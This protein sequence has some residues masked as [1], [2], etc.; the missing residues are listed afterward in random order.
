MSE[1]KPDELRGH[2]Y[3]GIEEYDNKLPNWWLFILYGSIVF[4]VGYWLVFHTF[5]IVDLPRARY[6]KEMVQAS[7]VQLAR[8]AKTGLTDESLA[9]MATI[10]AQVEEG[11]QLYATYCVVCHAD[12]GQGLVGPNLTDGFWIHGGRPLD[13]HKTVTDGVLS[14]GMAAWGRQLGPTRVQKVVAYV[15]TLKGTEVPGKAPEGVPEAAA[16]PA[17]PA[18]GTTEPV[19]GAAPTPEGAAGNG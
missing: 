19:S 2:V 15:L 14:K 6:D 5:S 16:A 11:R 4:A 7:E 13:I 12:R 1:H 9:L 3:D 8:L 17:T 18:A 10:P